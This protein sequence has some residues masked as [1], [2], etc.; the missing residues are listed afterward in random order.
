MDRDVNTYNVFNIDYKFRRTVVKIRKAFRRKKSVT[1]YYPLT[2]SIIKC[3]IIL[4]YT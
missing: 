1:A 2:K 4:L 3:N